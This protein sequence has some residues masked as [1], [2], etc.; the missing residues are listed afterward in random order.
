[1]KK[2][3]LILFIIGFVIQFVLSEL[4]IFRE[5]FHDYIYISFSLVLVLYSIFIRYIIKKL[6]IKNII[7]I[8]VI[9]T[10]LLNVISFIDFVIYPMLG[11]STGQMYGIVFIYGFYPISTILGIIYGVYVYKSNAN[12]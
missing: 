4:T 2:E 11:G 1:M 7:L 10:I 5:N 8:I 6:N 9:A 12:R 3:L